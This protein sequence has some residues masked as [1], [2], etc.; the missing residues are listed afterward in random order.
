M[1]GAAWIAVHLVRSRFLTPQIVSDLFA[2]KYY[3]S[4]RGNQELDWTPQHS[5]LESVERAWAFY[6]HEGLA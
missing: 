6:Q 2:F 4:R 1:A 3:S 5:F